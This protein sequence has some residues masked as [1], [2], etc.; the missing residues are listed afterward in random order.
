MK[1][2][3][4]VL[5]G[6]TRTGK[7]RFVLASRKIGVAGVKKRRGRER[8]QRHRR[9][10]EERNKKKWGQKR[11]R[12]EMAGENRKQEWQRR[13]GEERDRKQLRTKKRQERNRG[14]GQERNREK[15]G[16]R[17]L[18]RNRGGRVETEEAEMANKGKRGSRSGECFVATPKM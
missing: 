3:R 16:K 11:C 6:R 15:V 7:G 2:F 1:S 13:K 17:R 14:Y 10:G 9:K 12:G 4:D 18:G 5:N 8:T